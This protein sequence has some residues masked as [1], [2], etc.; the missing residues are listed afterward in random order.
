MKYERYRG[1]A[2]VRLPSEREEMSFVGYE[3]SR[4]SSLSL[5]S[6]SPRLPPRQSSIKRRDYDPPSPV[7]MWANDFWGEDF[8]RLIDVVVN[9]ERERD[10]NVESKGE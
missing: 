1:L 2:S 7:S 5:S 6:S 9:I 3:G 10:I 8:T 4:V